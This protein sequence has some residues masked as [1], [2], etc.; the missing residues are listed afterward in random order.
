MHHQPSLEVWK[1]FPPIL[2]KFELKMGLDTNLDLNVPENLLLL[3]WHW[4]VHIY[5]I[6]SIAP[7]AWTSATVIGSSDFC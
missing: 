3:G 7:V 6:Y 1:N 4:Q 2:Y 5:F